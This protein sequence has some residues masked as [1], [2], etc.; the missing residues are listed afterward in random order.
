MHFKV[1][2]QKSGAASIIVSTLIALAQALN[3]KLIDIESSLF[4]AKRLWY[5]GY[6]QITVPPKV[7]TTVL[8]Y[9]RLFLASVLLIR[10]ALIGILLDK[11]S[12]DGYPEEKM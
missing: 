5:R 7:I 1:A 9:F 8:I 12:D 2:F 6:L 3:L 4:L 10:A 11:L